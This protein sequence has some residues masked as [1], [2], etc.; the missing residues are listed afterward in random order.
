M[1]MVCRK[2]AKKFFFGLPYTA[3]SDIYCKINV[4]YLRSET[5]TWDGG[6]GGGRGERKGPVRK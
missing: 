1:Q 5:R 3:S 2:H 6:G 4:W